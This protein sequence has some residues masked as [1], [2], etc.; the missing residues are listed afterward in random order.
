[1]ETLNLNIYQS[2]FFEFL[3]IAIC[4]SSYWQ[5]MQ[6][7]KKWGGKNGLRNAAITVST[8]LHVPYRKQTG[9][10]V[11]EK[12]RKYGTYAAFFL[13]IAV[14]FLLLSIVWP[15]LLLCI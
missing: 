1:M 10:E 5:S 7:G 3:F 9:D 4:I 15:I 14:L 8:K 13:T 6:L 12:I 11:K 2:I